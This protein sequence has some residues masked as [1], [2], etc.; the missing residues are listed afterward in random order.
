MSLRTLN[1]EAL[2]NSF[3]QGWNLSVKNFEEESKMPDSNLKLSV[4][5]AKS[6]SYIKH[7]CKVA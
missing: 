3:H 5:K 4:P 2:V 1:T 7:L 6:S